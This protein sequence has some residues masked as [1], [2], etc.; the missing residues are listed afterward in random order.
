MP[1]VACKKNAPRVLPQTTPRLQAGRPVPG[2]RSLADAAFRIPTL[3]AADERRLLETFHSAA[4]AQQRQSAL[5]ELW[6]HYM[7]LVV[8]IA[9][10]YRVRGIER[11]DLIGAGLLGLHAAIVR[12]DIR[13][14][15]VRLAAYAVSWV[16]WHI[17]EY[18]RRNG[19]PVSLP[20]SDGHRKLFRARHRLFDDARQSCAGEGNTAPTHHELCARVGAFIGLSG[21]EVERSLQLAYGTHLSLDGPVSPETQQTLELPSSGSDPEIEAGWNLDAVRARRRIS[22]L[23]DR[24]LGASERLVFSRRCMLD[25][26]P[27][28]LEELAAE[29][30]V[31][32]ERVYQ[33]EGSAK[34]KIITALIAEGFAQ[35]SALEAVRALRSRSVRRAAKREAS[36]PGSIFVARCNIPCV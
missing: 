35:A 31:S 27:V 9:S 4:P 26:D 10:R 6:L 19:H 12:F 22:A 21:D 20:T 16:H 28:R 3:A 34:R 2:H 18:I 11:S 8:A 23:A 1:I 13:R 14:T 15:D 5:S 24:I 17:R 32:R 33:L 36:T 29:L 30:G 7:K 25:D